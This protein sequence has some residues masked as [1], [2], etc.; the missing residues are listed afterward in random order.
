MHK[1]KLGNPAETHLSHEGPLRKRL[2]SFFDQITQYQETPNFVYSRRPSQR[3]H[4]LKG[5]YL[6]YFHP[7]CF[8]FAKYP[9]TYFVPLLNF[10]RGLVSKLRMLKL[11]NFVIYFQRY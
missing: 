9:P 2:E 1:S 3:A 11:R 5:N 10:D 6:L 8:H 7:I 4:H